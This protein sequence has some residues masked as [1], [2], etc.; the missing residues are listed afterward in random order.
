MVDINA[1]LLGLI[2]EN[3]LKV[4]LKSISDEGYFLLESTLSIGIHHFSSIL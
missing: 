1:M 4:V 2:G 3:V